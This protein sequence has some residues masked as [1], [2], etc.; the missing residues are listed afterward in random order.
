ME[1]LTTAICQS[2]GEFHSDRVWTNPARNF[3]AECW[4]NFRRFCFPDFSRSF[5]DF[6]QNFCQLEPRRHQNSLTKLRLENFHVAFGL[7]DALLGLC[8][9]GPGDPLQTLSGF[10]G[11]RIV[12]GQGIPTLELRAAPTPCRRLVGM[13]RLGNLE[14]WESSTA[15][16]ALLTR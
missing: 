2:N 15:A 13:L 14:E 8:A 11:L 5:C 12:W 3:Q 9:G 6:L 7:R 16:L 10:Q 1:E 4:A